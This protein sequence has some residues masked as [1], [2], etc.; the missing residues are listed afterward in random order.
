MDPPLRLEYIALCL[1]PLGTIWGNICVC[2]AVY[3]ERRLRHRFN[4]FLVSLAISDLLCAILV[5]PVSAWHMIATRPQNRILC[6]VSYSMDIFF[7]ATTIIHLCSI[8]LDRYLALRRP[9]GRNRA[10]PKIFQS[11][12]FRIFMSWFVPFS[13]A[14]PLFVFALKWERGDEEFIVTMTPE[15]ANITTSK[16]YKGCG[17]NDKSFVLTA[18]GVTFVLPLIIMTATYVLTVKMLRRHMAQVKAIQLYATRPRPVSTSSVLWLRRDNSFRPTEI[19]RSTKAWFRQADQQSTIPKTTKYMPA[20]DSGCDEKTVKTCSLSDPLSYHNRPA[21][22]PPRRIPIGVENPSTQDEA[23]LSGNRVC[24]KDPSDKS[25]D[26]QSY[27][28][29]SETLFLTS[30]A[31]NDHDISGLELSSNH[32]LGLPSQGRRTDISSAQT[33]TAIDRIHSGKRAVR[34]IAVLFGLFVTCYTPF[35]IV[36]TISVVCPQCRSWAEP[37]IPHLE[38]LGYLNSMLNPVVYH[39]FNSTFRRTFRRIFQ[40]A[41]RTP[42]EHHAIWRSR[43]RV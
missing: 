6:L 19:N 15:S 17:P 40:C 33:T 32:E 36:Y 14:G 23:S 9:F 28:K 22:N 24:G 43:V 1:I 18:I 31:K 38:W 25:N 34:V 35:F 5:M 30:T 10:V 13:I 39:S 26:Q 27:V 3:L 37:A 12:V 11:L 41:C 7:T 21:E 20:S 4:L 42:H 2:L 8:S 16:S 29:A